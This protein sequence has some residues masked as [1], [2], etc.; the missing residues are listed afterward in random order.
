MPLRPC[1]TRRSRARPAACADRG[2]VPAG[3]VRLLLPARDDHLRRLARL[4]GHRPGPVPAAGQGACPGRQAQ[5]R[6][7]P[8]C[9]TDDSRR[10]RQHHRERHGQLR[11]PGGPSPPRPS[12]PRPPAT[13]PPR[14]G[15]PPRRSPPRSSTR[16][17]PRAWRTADLRTAGLD[18]AAN[19]EH[20]GNR[21]DPQRVHGH[22]PDRRHDPGPRAASGAC[23]TRGSRPGRRGSTAS[24]SS[25]RTRRPRPRSARR[26]A[27]ADARRRA[28]TI[29]DAL[30]GSARPPAG[31]R[32]R[33]RRQ[34]RRPC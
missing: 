20:D 2:P 25:S 11:P 24:P 18:V 16:C 3:A 10:S 12:W 34:A 13:A 7:Q 30:G 5:R 8:G 31:D 23:S 9:L 21:A 15:P 6:H 1:P 28:E 22:E 4:R 29:A 19:W 32:A 14:P 26:A 27:V 17:V 33:A